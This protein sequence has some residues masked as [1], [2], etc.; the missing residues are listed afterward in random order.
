MTFL[1]NISP[2]KVYVDPQYCCG[3]IQATRIEAYLFAVT[4]LLNRPLLFTVH[5]I[6]GAVYSRLPIEALSWKEKPQD[7]SYDKWGAIAGSGEFVQHPYLKDYRV[8]IGKEQGYYFGTIDYNEGGFAQDPEQHK[9]S[10]L[11]L[12]E[13]GGIWIVPNNECLFV[14]EHFTK[15]IKEKD[16]PYKRNKKY[17]R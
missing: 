6:H 9:T 16:L 13:K 2:L 14:D 10:N 8:K 4:L 3:G 17:Y 11:I 7:N 12:M 15:E 5:T 1:L